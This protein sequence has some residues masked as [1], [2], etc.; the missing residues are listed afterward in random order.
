MESFALLV[1]V[2]FLPASLNL[3]YEEDRQESFDD[4][5][6][7][8]LTS[9]ALKASRPRVDDALETWNWCEKTAAVVVVENL[10]CFPLYH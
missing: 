10:K 2:L 7:V 5:Q 1:K 4:G 3:E 9:N 6:Q 8:L